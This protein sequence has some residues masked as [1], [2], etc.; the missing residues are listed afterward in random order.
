[1][2]S[3]KWE[4]LTAKDFPKAVRKARGVC[5]IP[6]GCLEKHGDHLPVGTD[7]LKEMQQLIDELKLKGYELPL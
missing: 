4:E 7:L 6:L 3:M 1:M 5:V 2:I